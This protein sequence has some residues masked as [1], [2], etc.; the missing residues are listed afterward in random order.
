MKKYIIIIFVAIYLLSY[1][2]VRRSHLIVHTSSFSGDKDG[3]ELTYTHGVR[4]TDVIGL[5]QP[6]LFYIIVF[7]QLIYKPLM[8]SEK[9]Y[10]Y[11][12]EPRSSIW[13]YE[14]EDSY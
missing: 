9:M 11:M 8:F 2:E 6:R 5:L 7:A 13:Q 3:D 4:P 1:F 10:W 14:I 12:V